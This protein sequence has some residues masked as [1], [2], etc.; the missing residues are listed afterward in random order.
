MMVYKMVENLACNNNF[1]TLFKHWQ[2]NIVEQDHEGAS[3]N[4]MKKHSIKVKMRKE[5]QEKISR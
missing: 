4:R 3:R 2:F 1:V 5:E